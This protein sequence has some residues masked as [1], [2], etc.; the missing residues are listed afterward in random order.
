MNASEAVS[1]FGDPN[2][3]GI[4]F[5]HGI[6]LGREIWEPHARALAGRYRVVTVD[7]PGHGAL[8][9]IPF[10]TE[11]VTQLLDEAIASNLCGAPLVVGYSLGGYVAM[12]YGVHYPER[13]AAM[14]LAG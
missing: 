1:T 3:P 11:N 14:L 2:A 4:V 13:T 12:R 8:A 5:L 6:R 10:T 7:L 9:G